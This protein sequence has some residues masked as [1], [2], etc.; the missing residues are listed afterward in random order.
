M[1]KGLLSSWSLTTVSIYTC[2]GGI[3]FPLAFYPAED[4]EQWAVFSKHFLHFSSADFFLS[5][6]KYFFFYQSFTITL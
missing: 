5:K 4:R 1:G 2:F 3:L 6:N